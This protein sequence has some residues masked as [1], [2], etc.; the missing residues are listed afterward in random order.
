MDRGANSHGMTFGDRPG[1]LTARAGWMFERE[2][3]PA[4]RPEP[5]SYVFVDGREVTGATV[6]LFQSLLDTERLE[7]ASLGR[8]LDLL[9]SRAALGY[10]LKVDVGEPDAPIGE[11][12]RRAFESLLEVG[13]LRPRLR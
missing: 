3:A 9:C 5:V 6:T 12:C 8:Y 2:A 4:A 13:W 10:G 7:Q 1:G 11:R